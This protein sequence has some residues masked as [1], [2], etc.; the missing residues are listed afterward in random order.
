MT[1][2]NRV[3]PFGQIV[4]TPARGTFYGNRGGCFHDNNQQ[5]T[6]ARWASRQWIVCVLQFKGRHR[7]PLMQP[8][9]YTELFFLD[10]ATALAAGHRPCFE[11]RRADAKR[12]FEALLAGIPG[13]VAE[14]DKLRV[15]TVDRRL[16]DE[17]VDTRTKAKRTTLA[18]LSDLPDGAMVALPAHS[19][20]AFL[21]LETK[22][23]PWSFEGYGAP[24]SPPASSAVTVLTPPTTVAALRAGYSPTIHASATR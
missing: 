2:Q 3:D 18:V 4:A 21:K 8:G 5:L 17:R 19:S 12:F 23:L 22:L 6:R 24:V 15:D 10:E 11:C 1:L 9:L 16:H 20:R 14:G 7:E 13:L